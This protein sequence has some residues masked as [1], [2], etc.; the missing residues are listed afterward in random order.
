M[1]MTFDEYGMALAEVASMRSE[2]PFRQVGAVGFDASNRIVSMGYNG[3]PAGVTIPEAVMSDRELRQRYMI[4]AETNLMA[5][6][7]IG[8]VS[9][10]YITTMPCTEC[11]KN[12]VA[13]GVERVVYRD[14][15]V[16]SYAQELAS[17]FEIKL[18]LF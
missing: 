8:E 5:R 4:H 7:K 13:H 9:T 17:L 1:R 14:E 6:C 18:E 2:D 16:R 12:L 11:F 3:L 10:V 15:Y